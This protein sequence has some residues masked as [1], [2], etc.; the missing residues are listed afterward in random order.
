MSFNVLIVMIVILLQSSIFVRATKRLKDYGLTMSKTMVHTE[1]LQLPLR[2][3]G[4]FPAFSCNLLANSDG[5]A[6][7]ACNALGLPYTLKAFW[8]QH[9][10]QLTQWLVNRR[11]TAFWQESTKK[12]PKTHGLWFVSSYS[13]K[14]SNSIQIILDMFRLC[15]T[16]YALRHIGPGHSASKDYETKAFEVLNTG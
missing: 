12:V 2:G 16:S 5:S 8:N 10:L 6:P 9:A 7:S 3:P 14:S 13:N 4:H 11:S 1:T 15:F